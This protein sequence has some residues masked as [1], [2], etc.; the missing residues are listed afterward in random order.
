MKWMQ[1]TATEW[2]QDSEDINFNILRIFIYL[3]QIIFSFSFSF[4]YCYMEFY[5]LNFVVQPGNYMNIANSW[6][7]QTWR[8]LQTRFQIIVQIFMHKY[9]LRHVH[10]FETTR[11]LINKF[12]QAR[13]RKKHYGYELCL[14]QLLNL[15]CNKAKANLKLKQF[16][17]TISLSKN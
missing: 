16:A 10:K 5:L 2:I 1:A 9:L 7:P 8:L 12:R 17:G 11:K 13:S 4:Q 6:N 14:L 15:N 3:E